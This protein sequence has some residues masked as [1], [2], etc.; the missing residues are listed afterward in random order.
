ME[1]DKYECPLCRADI[2]YRIKGN[3]I[4][5]RCLGLGCGIKRTSKCPRTSKG[6]AIKVALYWWLRYGHM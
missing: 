1:T 5:V 3:S 6:R 2:D 4:T